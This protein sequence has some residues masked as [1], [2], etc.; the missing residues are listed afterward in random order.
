MNKVEKSFKET[1]V[2]SAEKIAETFGLPET[3]NENT[4]LNKKE[5]LLY[6]LK[7]ETEKK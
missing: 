3:K 6:K 5:S 2:K 7:K 1:V 4:G